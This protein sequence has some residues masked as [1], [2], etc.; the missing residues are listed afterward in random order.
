MADSPASGSRSATDHGQWHDAL[1]QPADALELFGRDALAVRNSRRQA[2]QR[3][4]I[5]IGQAELARDRANFGLTHTCLVQRAAH[6]LGT[7]GGRAG[8]RAPVAQVVD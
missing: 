4:F 7:F 1:V 2:R 3:R 5:S 6:P 8:T